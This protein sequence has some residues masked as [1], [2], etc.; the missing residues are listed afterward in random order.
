MIAAV[1]PNEAYHADARAGLQVLAER[2]AELVVPSIILPELASAL[3]RQGAAET[4]VENLLDTLDTLPGGRLVPVDEHV[5]QRSARLALQLR[6]RGC[7]AVYVAL[8]HLVGA[9][10]ISLDDEQRSRI[11]TGVTA[12]TPSEMLV[13]LT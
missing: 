9:T 8:A 7:D 3:A 13:R 10:L 1:R 2:G 6:L 4:D 12:L 11:P 5:A